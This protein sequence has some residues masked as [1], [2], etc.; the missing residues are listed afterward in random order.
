VAVNGTIG[1]VGLTFTQ[2]ATPQT[3][4]SVVPDWLFQPGANRVR[5][6]RVE[7]TRAGPRL[8]PVDLAA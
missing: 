3:F 1:A 6:Y 5:L 2:D 4:A 8:H 7:R